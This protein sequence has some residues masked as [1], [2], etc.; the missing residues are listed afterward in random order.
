MIVER[1]YDDEALIAIL[2]QGTV[3]DPHLTVCQSCAET[4]ESFRA[5]ADVLREP[6][7]WEV[8]EAP[9]R[10]PQA[11][12]SSLR[13]AAAQMES[14]DRD[15]EALVAELLAR[16]RS[17]WM[18]AAQSD[19]RFAQEGAVRCLIEKSEQTITKLPPEG[20]ALIRVAVTLAQQLDAPHV[21]GSAWRQ[22]AYALFYTGDFGGAA[23]AVYLAQAAFERCVAAEY[24]LARLTLTRSLISIARAEF[25]EAHRL[26]ERAADVFRAYE[27]RDRLAR[28]MG[29]VA[30]SL[31]V[32][33]RFAEAL[34][35]LRDINSNFQDVLDD[36]ARALTLCNLGLCLSETGKPGEAMQYYQAAEK[37]Y[38]ILG[39]RSEATRI[40]LNIA[41]LLA[42]QGQYEEAK[43][44]IRTCVREYEEFGMR[45][46]AVW[47]GLDLAEI[48]LIEK[49]YSEVDALCRRAIQ[50]YEESGVPHTANALTALTY[51][52]EAA[53]QKRATPEAARH[54]KV[55]LGRL[56]QQPRLQ[57]AP[58]PLPLD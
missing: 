6:A 17:A 20:L 32:Q 51:L 39:S 27:D 40:R 22:Y 57:F 36:D 29:T 55:Y 37:L 10:P 31:L 24:E 35:I 49:E 21:L 54:V 34:P 28:A 9:A 15:A 11:A 30:Y 14:E 19:R 50:Q 46:D 44:R 18:T 33:C 56:P 12:I 58:A 38:E 8:E 1:H 7:V 26:A 4:L 23:D 52:Q 16:P 13:A 53:A 42:G 5:I 25:A 48:L 47:A 2:N 45:T 41:C 3:R 43:K